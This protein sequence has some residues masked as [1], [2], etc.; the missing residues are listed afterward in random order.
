MVGAYWRLGPAMLK[1]PLEED[2]DGMAVEEKERRPAK[3]GASL[4]EM[5]VV[6]LLF[7]W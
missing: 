1:R 5:D 4:G 6:L 3:G 2:V 7:R